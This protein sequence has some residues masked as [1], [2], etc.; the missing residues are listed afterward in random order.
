MEFVL[1]WKGQARREGVTVPRRQNLGNR[2]APRASCP[3]PS[4]PASNLP[5][6]S[7]SLS[8]TSINHLRTTPPTRIR[9][10]AIVRARPV[11]YRTYHPSTAACPSLPSL[12]ACSLA[13]VHHPCDSHKAFDAGVHSCFGFT[14][15]A[16]VSMRHRGGSQADTSSAITHEFE[17]FSR[18]AGYYLST[19]RLKPVCVFYSER[20]AGEG[21]LVSSLLRGCVELG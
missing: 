3:L 14:A 5:I 19:T 9:A 4:R 7:P 20:V 1:G 21:F 12:P 18:V 15:L 2:G 16:L 6:F 10:S 8:S 17:L 13:S 11:R